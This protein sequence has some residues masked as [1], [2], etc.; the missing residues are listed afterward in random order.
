MTMDTTPETSKPAFGLEGMK[1]LI[2]VGEERRGGFRVSLSFCPGMDEMWESLT[3]EAL[4]EDKRDA[5]WLV[6]RIKK[7]GA[8]HLEHWVWCPSPCTPFASLQKKPTATLSKVA[9]PSRHR[10]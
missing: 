10:A 5:V 9:I 1:R 2:E 7:A 6:E 4:F 3:H 8:I